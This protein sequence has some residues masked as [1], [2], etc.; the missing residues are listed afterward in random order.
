M[1]GGYVGYYLSEALRSAYDNTVQ[2]WD[3]R[4]EFKGDFYVPWQTI[5]SENL[6]EYDAILFFAGVS[7]VADAQSKPVEACEQNVLEVWSLA[8]G[9]RNGQK[10]IYAS[11]G[12]VYSNATSFAGSAYLATSSE[13]TNLPLSQS[14]YDS[15]NQLAMNCS[16]SQ[17]YRQQG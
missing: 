12:S 5:D 9:L 17:A 2:T 4:P 16:G 7:S 11:S 8:K 3:S 13:N 6:R 15:S 10:L 14:S 1:G